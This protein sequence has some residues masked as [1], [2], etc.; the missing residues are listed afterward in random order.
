MF[1][2]K[3][4]MRVFTCNS[5]LQRAGRHWAWHL[6]ETLSA[7]LTSQP[8]KMLSKGKLAYSNSPWSWREGC[9]G[10]TRGSERESNVHRAAQLRGCVGGGGGGVDGV[11]GS[12][13]SSSS[14]TALRRLLVPVTP[15][16]PG[17][18]SPNT[19]SLQDGAC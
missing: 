19:P 2:K 18:T 9:G 1:H 11:E 4:D 16:T 8:H 6:P 5:P 13:L 14:R 7:N 3:Q 10:R 17:H 15:R 12:P